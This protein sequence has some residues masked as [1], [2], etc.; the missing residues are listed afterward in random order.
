M[1]TINIAK[2]SAAL[3]VKRFVF[4]STIGVNG[5]NSGSIP[6]TEADEPHP[7]NDYSLS[8][9]QAELALQEISRE[10]GMEIVIVRAPLIY[11]P[12]NPGNFHS[13]LRIVSRKIPLP[14]ASVANRRS[15]LY[16]GNLVDALTL[17]ATHQ[18]APGRTYL[19]SDGEDITTPELIRLTARALGV[20]VWLLPFPLSLIV[21]AGKLTGKSGAVNGLI[22]SLT[23]DSSRIKAELGWQ[24]PFT[25]EEGLRET[26][27][28][29]KAQL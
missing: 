12:G 18:A 13:L 29:F 1:G 5:D 7:H 22:G 23:V 15:F 27:A 21:I 3:G 2:Q 14:L 20:A 16:A 9:Y 17:C 19:V 25:M 10:T 24:P 8:K 6:F 28:W 11:G 4:M 26:A